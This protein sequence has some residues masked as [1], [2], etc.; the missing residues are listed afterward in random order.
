MAKISDLPEAQGTGVP[1]AGAFIPIVRLVGGILTTFKISVANLMSFIQQATQ[2]VI[3]IVKFST[4]T[5]ITTLSTTTVIAP[6]DLNNWTPPYSKTKE[7]VQTI[8]NPTNGQTVFN[9]DSVQ[10]NNNESFKLFINGE[11]QDSSRYTVTI[12]T[13]PVLSTLT[14][15]A[16]T[17]FTIS[18]T[19]VLTLIYSNN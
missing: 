15:T 13:L 4:P 2:S 16:T 5:E 6:A 17:L 1:E 18:S 10:P 3:G 12:N 14:W 19:D 7:H 9:L 11:L 8:I